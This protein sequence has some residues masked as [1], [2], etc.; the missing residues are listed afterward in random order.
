MT[1]VTIVTIGALLSFMDKSPATFR[2]QVSLSIC[3][4][5]LSETYQLEMRSSCIV[6]APSVLLLRSALA[7]MI[8]AQISAWLIKILRIIINL[9]RYQFF[10]KVAGPEFL[11]KP[12]VLVVLLD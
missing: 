4:I 5:R 10:K 8:V 2:Y 3:R 1:I 7:M 12:P 6:A 11:P 9:Q